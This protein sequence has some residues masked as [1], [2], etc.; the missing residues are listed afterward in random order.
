[1]ET[2]LTNLLDFLLVE[3]LVQVE[4]L[5][6]DLVELDVNSFV[7]VAETFME[8]LEEEMLE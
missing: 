8:L 1:M 4:L 3:H 2:I 6:A 7:D 5:E